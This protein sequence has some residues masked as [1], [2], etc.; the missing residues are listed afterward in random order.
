[1][2]PILEIS[3]KIEQNA[4]ELRSISPENV[5]WDVR[6]HKT[7][8][9]LSSVLDDVIG[10]LLITVPMVC[11]EIKNVTG[12]LFDQSS[13]VEFINPN[14]IIETCLVRLLS[15]E[16]VKNSSSS[17]PDLLDCSKED[18]SDVLEY[19]TNNG[20]PYMRGGKPCNVPDGV[21]IKCYGTKGLP[22][23]DAHGPQKGL[24]I[25]VQWEKTHDDEIVITNVWTG[26]VI[27]CDKVRVT[28]TTPSSTIKYRLRPNCMTNWYSRVPI[29]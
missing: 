8:T 16:F 15:A 6:I 17:Y 1:M 7:W 26:L 3:N 10:R 23:V 12:V 20:K 11:K 19:N 4:E 25:V 27:E 28:S 14:Q 22:R 21:E 9:K 24:H 18:Y 13:I 2:D 5:E 29:H